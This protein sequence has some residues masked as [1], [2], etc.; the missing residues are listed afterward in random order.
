MHR[1]LN[2]LKS[3]LFAQKPQIDRR[4][5]A[6]ST[7]VPK[8]GDFVVYHHLKMKVGARTSQELWKWLQ[9]HGWR[10]ENFQNDRRRYTLL[11]EASYSRLDLAPTSERPMIIR[12]FLRMK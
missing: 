12:S 7:Q 8:T 11:P 9:K 10:V 5:P 3:R 2:V 1:V 6:K 4:V